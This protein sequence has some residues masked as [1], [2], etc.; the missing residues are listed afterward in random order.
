MKAVGVFSL[1]L[2]VLTMSC[3]GSSGNPGDAV[4]ELFDALKAGNGERAVSYMSDEALAEVGAQLE[5]VK[6]DPEASAAQLAAAGIEIDAAGIP[7]MTVKEFAAAI[8]SSPMI[9]TVMVSAELSIDEVATSGDSAKVEVTTT[10]MGETK[11]YTIDVI[12][13]DG[14]WKVTQFRLNM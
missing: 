4:T 7:D 10:F 12:K 8:Y 9:T 2:L 13:I 3:G 6:L 1:L 5:M 14:L 11:T